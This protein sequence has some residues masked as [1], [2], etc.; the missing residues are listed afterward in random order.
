M[1]D[2]RL[3][4]WNSPPRFFMTRK[5]DRNENGVGHRVAALQR[6]HTMF[7]TGEP[8]LGSQYVSAQNFSPETLW[9]LSFWLLSFITKQSTSL[10]NW[11]A[12]WGTEEPT[13]TEEP[14]LGS[15]VN[16]PPNCL[17][18]TLG[19]VRSYLEQ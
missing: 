3:G 13:L 2:S 18:H 1:S 6:R 17:V 15:R 12:N 10:F 5:Q 11:G 19:T 4:M 14:F 9:L 8:E 7:L 16:D